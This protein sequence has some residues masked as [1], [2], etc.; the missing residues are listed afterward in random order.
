MRS[1]CAPGWSIGLIGVAVAIGPAGAT[2]QEDGPATGF[3]IW[4]RVAQSSVQELAA[5]ASGSPEFTIGRRGEKVS[6]GLAMGLVTLR[7]TDRDDFGTGV[8]ESKTTATLF[9]LGPDVLI[10][11]W[12]S[13]DRQT[14]GSIALGATIGRLSAKDEDSFTGSP[15]SESKVSGTLFGFRA[16]VGGDHYFGRHFALGVEAGLQATFATGV[17][18]EGSTQTIGVGAGGAYGAFRITL[19]LASG[20]GSGN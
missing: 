10:R 20:G 2:A 19:V 17:E 11:M 1:R 8:S 4:A 9:Q 7:V 18:E 6:L 16:G 5:S 14:L 12:E 15:T 3:S 13:A